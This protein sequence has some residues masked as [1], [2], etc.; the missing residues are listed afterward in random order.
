VG[1]VWPLL[2]VSVTVAVH[3]DA[4]PTATAPGEQLTLVEV[5]SVGGE[6]S[7]ALVSAKPSALKPPATSTRP[8]TSKG[9]RVLTVGGVQRPG[10]GPTAGRGVIQLHA[11]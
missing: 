3:V 10:R 1:V 11:R 4:V 9:R 8:S 6:N 2:S 7:S 5:E